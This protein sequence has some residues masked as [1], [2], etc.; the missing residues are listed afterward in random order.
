MLANFKIL[1][2]LLIT[3]LQTHLSLAVP[4]ETAPET[5]K[6]RTALHTCSVFAQRWSDNSFDLQAFGY[7]WTANG[8]FQGIAKAD[9][10]TTALPVGTVFTTEN[11]IGSYQFTAVN[12]AD[13][14]VVNG[15][16]DWNDPGKLSFQWGPTKFDTF[17]P[18]N[19][20]ITIAVGFSPYGWATNYT[21]P[22]LCDS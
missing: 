19:T 9:I 16:V 5:F 11:Y 2:V 6:P 20:C 4:V 22:F 10:E 14:A 7:N 15:Q 21:C 12:T 17:S 13:P 8:V 1:T 3:F 18:G